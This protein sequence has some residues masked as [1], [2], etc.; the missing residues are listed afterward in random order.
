[1]QATCA[2]TPCLPSRH[3]IFHGLYPCQSGIYTNGDCMPVDRIPGFT[4]AK[5]FR[6]AG[7]QTAAFG[8]M[9][10]F[11][12]QAA[13]ERGSYFGFES[14]A[15]HFHETG[16]K[17]ST[18]FVK[19]HRDQAERR[20]EEWKT[21]GIGKGG[22]DCAAAFMGFTSS[23]RNEERCDWWS[24]GQAASFIDEQADRPFLLVCSLIGPHAPHDVPIDFAGLYDPECAPMPPEW[25][26]DLPDADAYDR[27]GGLSRDDLRTAITNYMAYVS[28]TDA[29]HARVID[30]LERNG[31]YEDTMV[32]YMSD[33]G[34]LLGSRG[35]SAFSK[36]NL[37]E[38][39]IRTPLIVKL[40]GPPR[41]ATS[42]TSNDSLVSLVDIL[43]TV[44]DVAGLPID[45]Q[46]AGISLKPALEGGAPERERQIVFTEFAREGMVHLS[47][48]EPAWKVIL[49]PYGEELYHLLDDPWE[50]CNLAG[51]PEFLGK[52]EELKS[53]FIDEYRHVF[54]RQGNLARHYNRQD[55]S[56]LSL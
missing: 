51:L 10:W 55:W 56:T 23:L 31:L 29:C 21:H 39:A 12:Y 52:K 26:D 50:L 3:S 15:A 40:P 18:H 34:E 19:E 20:L 41:T 28:A 9:H 27:F 36:Y 35:T 38:R 47:I 13:V 49:G 45:G 16:E 37:Y 46:L 6:N 11:P 14:R 53:K 42:G 8:K 1:T 24:A 2:V 7:F 32:I 17:M 5:T 30:A 43:P 48:R 33:H 44:L 54:S 22:D 25:P 4:M